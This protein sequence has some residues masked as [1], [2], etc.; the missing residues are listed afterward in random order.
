MAE[1]LD[2]GRAVPPEVPM[3][4]KVIASDSLNWAAGQ[5]MQLLGGRGYMENNLAP[6]ILRDARLYSVGEG[7]NEVL[8]TQ[9]GRKARLTDTI[10]AYLRASP[11]GAEPAD[12]LAVSIREIADRCLHRTGP[13]VDR[14]SA[15]LWIDALIGAVAS[16]TLLLVAAQD[17]EGH[18][19]SSDLQ[20]G[21]E[22]AEARLA[23]SV[24]KGRI[25]SPEERLMPTPSAAAATIKR[26]ADSIGDVEQALAGEEDSLDVYLMREPGFD[27]YPPE[28]ELPGHVV[29]VND[30]STAAALRPLIVPDAK[31]LT[32]QAHSPGPGTQTTTRGRS[33]RTTRNLIDPASELF[34]YSLYL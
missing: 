34:P 20:R 4:A 12:V 14:S 11:V 10:D 1:R 24:E 7:P 6:Q 26:Y 18:R 31:A 30:V 9:V 19:P 29:V 8:T 3:A 16:D 28:S 23:R 15:Q 17:A 27:P 21:V 5:L 22:W 25:G 13:F 33:S 2:S 32:S